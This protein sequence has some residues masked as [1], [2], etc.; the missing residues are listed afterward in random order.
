MTKEVWSMT[1]FNS[2]INV[3]LNEIRL[4]RAEGITQLILVTIK[5]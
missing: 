1:F 5:L 2:F 4:K 3:P